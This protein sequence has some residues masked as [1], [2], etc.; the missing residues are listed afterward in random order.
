[1]IAGQRIG[2]A[3]AICLSAAA[4]AEASGLRISDLRAAPASDAGTRLVTLTVS[5]R[6]GWRHERNHDAV[7]LFVKGA[8]DRGQWRHLRI[9]ASGHRVTAL[10]GPAGEVV[11][12]ADRA[13]VFVVPAAAH[14]GPV[15]WQVQLVVEGAGSVDV[16]PFGL[17]MV[18][19]PSGP[20]TLGDPDP[21]AIEYA[22]VFRSNAAGQPDGLVRIE[23]EAAIDVGARAGALNYVAKAPQYEGDRQGPIPGPFPKGFAAFYIMKYET[24]QGMYA[25][26][27]NLVHGQATYFRAIHGGRGYTEGRG[28]IR[29]ESRRYV[30][31][32][33]DRPAN[34]I[35][36]N[37]GLAFADWAG[38]RPMTELEF[39]K[40]A[41][42]PST[43]V[44]HEFP[45]G[46]ASFDRLKRVM[47]P[48]DDLVT[49]GEAD[50]ARL[51]DATR[52]ALGASFF[53]VMDLAG[54][55]WERVIS[56]GHPRGRAF[57]GTHGDGALSDYGDATNDDWPL[58]DQDTGGYGY[59]GGGYYERG[60]TFREFNPYSPIAYRR[61]GSWG[62]G[63]RSIAYGFRA[64][65]T[66]P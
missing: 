26:F 66:A 44:A 7:W 40:A 51:S 12:P 65:R 52:A 58:G 13:G 59:R 49:G 62:G 31:G 63:P 53:W 27:L 19:V 54:S 30:A 55:V 29:L 21:R 5:W 24:S 37:D 6:N 15:S 28:T 14:R 57:R 9:A 41:R 34:W 3:L 2:F 16:R 39:T 43:P 45:W 33:P 10:E 22:A 32:R 20:F 56:F 38:L 4:M 36:W 46:T 47:G 42:G 35:S 50:E 23:S 64:V 61:F 18:H 48:D 25:D 1:M 11:V 60:M 17:E 8:S